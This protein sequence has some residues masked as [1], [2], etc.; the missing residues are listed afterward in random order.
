MG[1]SPRA[2]SERLLWPRHWHKYDKAVIGFLCFIKID[3]TIGLKIKTL[4]MTIKCYNETY[5]NKSQR[6]QY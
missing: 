5:K 3:F 4:F 6:L 2:F 1:A